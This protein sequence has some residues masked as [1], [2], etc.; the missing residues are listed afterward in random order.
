[1]SLSERERE[2]KNAFA[3]YKSWPSIECT[4]DRTG[5]ESEWRTTRPASSLSLSLSLTSAHTNTRTHTLSSTFKL[6]L[7]LLYVCRLAHDFA[8]ER[9]ERETDRE[10]ERERER[11]VLPIE[12]I[13]V[14]VSA[15]GAPASRESTNTDFFFE[16]ARERVR[17]RERERERWSSCV[18]LQSLEF[19]LDVRTCRSRVFLPSCGSSSTADQLPR[20]AVHFA[21]AAAAVVFSRNEETHD[22]KSFR[23]SKNV[24]EVP[25][26]E[27]F[28]ECPGKSL[29]R[30]W[31]CLRF[32][33]LRR[34]RFRHRS[35]SSIGWMPNRPWQ[36]FHNRW[37]PNV[38][39]SQ[40]SK[41]LVAI[42][43]AS[44]VVPFA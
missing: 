23:F 15:K 5:R 16:R 12:Y 39:S 28:C 33:V 24:K 37:E 34:F 8:I 9:E 43:N 30:F 14:L 32:K 40:P 2:V 18:L 41:R 20:Q 35:S 10:R 27:K 36:L 21:A 4:R 44:I 3:T 17:E 11:C 13:I 6:S 26:S 19:G 29:F 42:T 7:S 31:V 1:M 25:K 22:K 38:I